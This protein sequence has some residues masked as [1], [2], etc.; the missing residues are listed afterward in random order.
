MITKTDT[1]KIERISRNIMNATNDLEDEI[2]ALFKRFSNV[3]TVTKEW[4][5]NQANYYF[6]RVALDKRQYLMLVNR[7]RSVAKELSSEASSMR[8]S[9]K[10]NNTKD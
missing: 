3:P 9:I 6:S 5:G 8:A 7:L 1:E 10:S 4:I 2:N